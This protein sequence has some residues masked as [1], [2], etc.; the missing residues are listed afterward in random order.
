MCLAIPAEIME[1]NNGVA[2]CQ[3][4]QSETF[5]DV[6]LMLLPEEPKI[7]QFLIVHAGFALR[8]MDKEEAEES[9]SLLREVVTAHG[10]E[11]MF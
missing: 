2:K 5:I 6:G 4:G 1:I 9:L 3:V 11:V 10:D 8:V 7:G